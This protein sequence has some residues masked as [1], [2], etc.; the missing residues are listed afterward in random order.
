MKRIQRMAL[1]E[2]ILPKS[3]DVEYILTKE[4]GTEDYYA[5]PGKW[6][7]PKKFKV[8]GEPV[9]ITGEPVKIGSGH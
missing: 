1:E 9:K 8:T 5:L 3:Q 4:Q 6:V 2:T 7:A